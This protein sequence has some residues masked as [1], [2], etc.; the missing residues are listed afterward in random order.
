MVRLW[1]GLDLPAHVAPYALRD[2]RLGYIKGYE[3]VLLSGE[4]SGAALERAARA[5]WAEGWRERL[6]QARERR[7]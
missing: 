3:S 4:L 2:A 7:S 6:E 1:E 5:R